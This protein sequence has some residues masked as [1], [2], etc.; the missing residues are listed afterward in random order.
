MRLKQQIV[1]ILIQE[2]VANID[3]NRR[4]VVLL[5]HWAGGR[6]SE[7]RVK[8]SETAKHRHC[9]SLDAVEV[10][11]KMAEKFPDEQ[12]ASTLNRFRRRTGADNPGNE[13]RV[14]FARHHHGMPSFDASQAGPNELV[15]LQQAALRLRLSPPSVC[16]MVEANILPGDQVVECAPWPIPVT[17]LELRKAAMNLK[18][19]VR[20]SRNENHENQQCL[21]SSS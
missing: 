4:E 10:T 6:H 9:T 1:Q 2:I 21:F 7:L 19:R 5:I 13:N 11:S 18:N 14:Y 15:T 3:E 20:V 16:K 12:I 17:A 8:K